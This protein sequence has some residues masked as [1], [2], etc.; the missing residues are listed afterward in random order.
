[1][2][3]LA[4]GRTLTGLA[5]LGFLATAGLHSTGYDTVTQ[6]A[7]EVPFD[8]GPVMPALWLMFS[9]DLAIIGLIV[10]TVAY[11]P[12]PLARLILV[13]A[14]FSPLGAAGL[15]LRF[16]GF[17]PPTAI[18]LAVGALTLGAAAV[19]PPRPPAPAA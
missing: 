3:R 15:Q 4:V 6:L 19:L 7:A 14:A 1:M 11:C 17:V 18:L 16:I 13:I 9:I 12:V 2:T 10:A 8:L 5:A